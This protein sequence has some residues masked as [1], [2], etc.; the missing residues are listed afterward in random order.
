MNRD[1]KEHV[2]HRISLSEPIEQEWATEWQPEWGEGP[3]DRVPGWTLK[4]TKV[5]DET[6]LD[7]NTKLYC[8]ECDLVLDGYDASVI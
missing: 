4:R 5:T 8:H 1:Y 7:E 3:Q 2:N 6:V